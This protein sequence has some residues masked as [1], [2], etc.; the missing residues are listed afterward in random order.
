MGAMSSPDPRMRIL[1]ATLACIGS[2][3][4]S[5]T[6]VEDIARAAGC[7]RAT[8]YRY[9]PGG[10]DE[11]VEA[12]VGAAMDDFFADLAD[13]GTDARSLRARLIVVLPYARRAILGHPTL[14]RVLALEPDLILP[15]LTTESNRLLPLIAEFVRPL[16]D[17]EV[18]AGRLS[19]ADDLDQR[20]AYL[21]RMLLSLISS[22]AGIDLDDPDA[23]GE[24]V[25]RELLVGFVTH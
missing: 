14:Q 3:G 12:A 21:A 6:S 19:A 2:V 18:V 25:D 8:V 15:L 23:V 11:L 16:L 7:S 20:A 24:L 17:D 4:L 5:K 13:V 9:F 1:D 22:P 10:R